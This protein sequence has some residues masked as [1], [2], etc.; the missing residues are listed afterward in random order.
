MSQA[1]I[2]LLYNFRLLPL[3]FLI[4]V[5]NFI[6]EFMSLPV[7]CVARYERLKYSETNDLTKLKV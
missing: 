4:E 7:L 6:M 1:D 2:L 3:L 5:N